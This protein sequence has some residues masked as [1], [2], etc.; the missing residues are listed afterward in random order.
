M[1]Q[2]RVAEQKFAEMKLN[3]SDVQLKLTEVAGDRD[4]FKR[5]LTLFQSKLESLEEEK[6]R[7]ETEFQVK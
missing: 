2:L 4:A 1:N 5:D 6:N 3:Y 7:K